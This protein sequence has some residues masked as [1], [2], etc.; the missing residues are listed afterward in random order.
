MTYRPL[1]ATLLL[2]TGACATTRSGMDEPFGPPWTR[3]DV[4]IGVRSYDDLG[5]TD[6]ATALFLD[7]EEGDSV[8]PFGLEG[9]IH[10]AWD[11]RSVS[12]MTGSDEL[13]A[14]T[15]EISAGLRRQL[16]D[17]AFPIVPYLGAGGSLLFARLRTMDAGGSFA[18]DDDVALGGYAKGG[19]L[20]R[21]R[22]GA[23]IGVEVRRLLTGPLSFGGQELDG[24][25][26]QIA[27]V[28]AA[29][30]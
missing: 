22:R 13:T 4:G 9:G 1:G 3:L 14:R 30:L 10:Y 26:T 28:F 11:R 16:D 19:L 23:T 29:R 20:L 18:T 25:A 5:P 6:D 15:V 8:G 2:L 27:L 7:Y 21:L 17:P 24:D 12:T